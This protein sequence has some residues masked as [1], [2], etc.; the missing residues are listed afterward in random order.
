MP[1]NINF[2]KKLGVINQTSITLPS[3][4]PTFEDTKSFQFDGAL[5]R[6]EGV[7]TY[8]Q[9]D[10]LKKATFSFWL[11]PSLTTTDI[12]FAIM[13]GSEPQARLLMYSNGIVRFNFLN[14]G[15]YTT[16]PMGSITANV[17]SHVL[18]CF[19]KDS[20]LGNAGWG[21]VFI[22]G[23]YVPGQGNNLNNAAFGVS[24]SGIYIGSQD[25]SLTYQGFMNEFAIWA[26]EDL[27]SASDVAEI[28]NG[29]VPNDLNSLS[30]VP[31]PTTWQRM[32]E[33]A[34]WDGSKF[35]MTD[36]NGGYVNTSIGLLPTDP[37]PTTDVPLFNN[38]SFT[39]DGTG[40]FVN[41]A[42]R[43]QN[44]TDFTVSVWFKTTPKGGYNSIIG[45]SAGEG[46]LLFAIVQAGGIIR[47]RDNTWTAL[48]G[49]ITD[50]AWHHLAITYD[51]S[52][53]EL[54]SYVD[55]S[56][57]TTLTPGTPSAPTNSHSFNQIGKRL[58][59]GQWLGNLDELA[60]FS[61]VLSASDVSTIYGTGAATSLS[62]FN[63][64]HWWRAEQVTFDGTDWT[65]IDQGSG[66]NNGTSSSMPFT[67]RS[68]DVPT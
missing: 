34:V 31:Q 55:N 47:L 48:S 45:N 50:D 64:V 29:G 54:K 17:W 26:G 62:T 28:Y 7:G 51:N 22:N 57:F 12:Q 6:F 5:D 67:S 41:L 15:Y 25:T 53:N 11:K 32:G 66:S 33:D 58:S 14:G 43:T 9:L 21:Q 19:D 16:T 38:K 60:V 44:F 18:F 20:S 46:G 1:T 10:G 35:V 40:D 52:A 13:N 59:I 3:S 30:T 61:S 2:N 68:S 23:V 8:S 65:L 39:Y 37:N 63:P 56:P 24:T 49:S 4:V 42:S 36:V 27:R